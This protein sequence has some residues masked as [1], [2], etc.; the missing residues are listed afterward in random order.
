MG[1]T[2]ITTKDFD[3]AR[4][5]TLADSILLDFSAKT[6]SPTQVGRFEIIRHVGRGGMGDVYLGRDSQLDR[7]VAIKVP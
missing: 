7:L 1:L 4:P 3:S 5:P 6:H 2:E